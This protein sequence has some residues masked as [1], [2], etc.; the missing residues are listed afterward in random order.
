ME[1]CWKNV[2]SYSR[3]AISG[4][5]WLIQ[6]KTTGAHLDKG[7]SWIWNIFSGWKSLF[8]RITTELY[9]TAEAQKL[10]IWSCKA[11]LSNIT[12]CHRYQL[13]KPIAH[14][15]TQVK[16]LVMMS[17]SYRELLSSIVTRHQALNDVGYSLLAAAHC[18][19]HKLC[20]GLVQYDRL[21]EVDK[22]EGI[23][24]MV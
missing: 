2:V 20:M 19:C 9:P 18:I 6:D 23:L 13:R 16:L 24:K 8:N 22:L 11:K 15:K 1:K 10:D 14:P 4:Y 12:C 3:L 5:K 17:D 7:Q 21:L